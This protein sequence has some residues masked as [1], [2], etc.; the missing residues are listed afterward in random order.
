M[1]RVQIVD[2]HQVGEGILPVYLPCER[3]A[4]H[5]L[6]LRLDPHALT[7]D[8]MRDDY[9]IVTRAEALNAM[10][11]LDNEL[12]LR[13]KY[14]LE[15][16]NPL[17]WLIYF[18]KRSC[19]PIRTLTIQITGDPCAD[20]G[21]ECRI[22]L[23]VRLAWVGCR[24]EPAYDSLQPRKAEL[25]HVGSEVQGPPTLI[26][27]PNLPLDEK[28]MPPHIILPGEVTVEK[29]E[30]KVCYTVNGYEALL[31]L[32]QHNEAAFQWWMKN[33]D[34]Y[35]INWERNLM[36]SVDCCEVV[37]RDEEDYPRT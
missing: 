11:Q 12:S 4:W 15:L 28:G 27:F 20:D 29:A 36:F 35:W 23:W 13:W 5:G 8:P 31:A 37:E 14:H 26:L 32:S 6:K 24:L 30:S 18:N 2:V 19:R 33:H 10:A 3:L 34:E 21:P 16:E 17:E 9:Y 1:S 22:P 25:F 7:E